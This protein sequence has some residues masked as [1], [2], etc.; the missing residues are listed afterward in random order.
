ML[1]FSDPV[2]GIIQPRNLSSSNKNVRF[3]FVL[4]TADIIFLYL[5]PAALNNSGYN[6]SK[7]ISFTG[8]RES[9]NS[10]V[11]RQKRKHIYYPQTYYD[12]FQMSYYITWQVNHSIYY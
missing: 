12:V 7:L 8:L 3:E 10:N 2:A 4:L 9:S 6:E 11:S 5:R 1:D